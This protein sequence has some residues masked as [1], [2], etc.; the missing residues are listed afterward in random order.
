MKPW[1]FE[2]SVVVGRLALRL[3]RE[4][5]GGFYRRCALAQDGRAA[6]AAG[7]GAGGHHHVAY[8]VLPAASDWPMAQNW[9]VFVRLW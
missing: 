7:R 1:A 9:Q 2:P 3:D 5:D 4:I 6:I 8:A